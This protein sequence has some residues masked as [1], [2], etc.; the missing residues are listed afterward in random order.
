MTDDTTDPSQKNVVHVVAAAIV[1]GSTCLVGKRRENDSLAGRWEFPGGK[2]EPEEHPEQALQR[3][4][5]EELG[6]SIRIVRPVGRGTAVGSSRTI[7]LDVYLARL[8]GQEPRALEHQDL[9]WVAES[10]LVRLD[11]A[12]ADLFALDEVIREMNKTAE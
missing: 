9:R 8:T 6:T 3:E 1:R 5:R 2:V 4:I 11:L 7:L 10:E 12:P